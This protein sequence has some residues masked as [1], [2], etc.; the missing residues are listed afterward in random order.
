MCWTLGGKSSSTGLFWCGPL[1]TALGWVLYFHLLQA[2]CLESTNRKQE[3]R[4]EGSPSKGFPLQQHRRVQRKTSGRANIPYPR[5]PTKAFSCRQ[6][7]SW[8]LG[9]G[10]FYRF[11]RSL[12]V[13]PSHICLP[14]R[15]TESETQ[16]LPGGPAIEHHKQGYFGGIF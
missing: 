5:F 4:E 11:G 9:T 15:Q 13:T 10:E 3:H 7:Q 12:K 6:Q 14:R 2:L 8:D 16:R 1:V